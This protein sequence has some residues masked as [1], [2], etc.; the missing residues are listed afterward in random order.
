MR[1]KISGRKAGVLCNILREFCADQQHFLDTESY[2]WAGADRR[3][4]RAQ[5]RRAE[6]LIAQLE[7]KHVLSRREVDVL[8]GLLAEFCADQEHFLAE[9]LFSD[10]NERR[11]T[12]RQLQLAQRLAGWLRRRL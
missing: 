9:E 3:M 12:L 1:I 4:V 8:L 6:K 2:W 11:R 7:M 10:D 5:L